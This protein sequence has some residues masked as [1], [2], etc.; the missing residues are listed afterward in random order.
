MRVPLL[1]LQKQWAEIQA[2]VRR[3][4]DRVWE[5]QRFIMGPEVSGLEEEIA[6]YCHCAHAVGLS[7]GTDALPRSRAEVI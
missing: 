2:D 4:V 5:S 3:A 7:S 6:A 1:D